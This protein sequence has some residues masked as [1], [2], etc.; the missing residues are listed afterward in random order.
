MSDYQDPQFPVVETVPD[1]VIF[2]ASPD[3]AL[4]GWPPSLPVELAMG[5]QPT[6]TICAAYDISKEQFVRLTGLPA[7]Q[8]AFTDA[9]EMLQKDGMAFRMK[10]RMQSE[11]LLPESWRLIHSQYTPPAVKAKLIEATWRVAGFEPK[12][13]DRAPVVPLQINISL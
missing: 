3:P 6:K 7:F 11:A 2:A 10:A 1:A 5:E 4:I 13:S 12:E 9:R 8:K